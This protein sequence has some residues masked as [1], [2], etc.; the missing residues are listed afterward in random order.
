M[1]QRKD[2]L[3]PHTKLHRKDKM[4][5]PLMLGPYLLP[6]NV[7]LAHQTK[8]QRNKPMPKSKIQTHPLLRNDAFSGQGYLRSQCKMTHPL[9]VAPHLLSRSD[10]LVHRA[11]QQTH[12]LLLRNDC[13]SRQEYQRSQCEL[14]S[15]GLPVFQN[16]LWRRKP[17]QWNPSHSLQLAGRMCWNIILKS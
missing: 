13:F 5:H 3:C 2:T 7:A 9:M 16:V 10:P 15:Q 1:L 8:P 4:T 14:T 12:S 17:L 11:K 6:R